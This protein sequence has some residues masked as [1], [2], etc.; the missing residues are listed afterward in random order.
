MV[1]Q[2][3]GVIQFTS[4][5]RAC[6]RVRCIIASRHDR[7]WGRFR[8][9]DI[10]SRSKSY[11]TCTQRFCCRRSGGPANIMW[12]GTNFKIIN[13]YEDNRGVRTFLY[14]NGMTGCLPDNLLRSNP[15]GSQFILSCRWGNSAKTTIPLGTYDLLP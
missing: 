12:S 3:N 13:V 6:R 10:R 9:T 7:G 11:C 4:N 1:R 2:V 15:W 8:I 14:A 5:V